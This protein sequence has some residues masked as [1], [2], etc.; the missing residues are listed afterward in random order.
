MGRVNLFRYTTPINSKCG[1]HFVHRSTRVFY[2]TLGVGV[3]GHH[4]GLI[5]GAGQQEDGL[6]RTR[7]R[8]RYNGQFFTTQR[9]VSVL[10]QFSKEL[11]FGFCLTFRTI[12]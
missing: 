8:Y 1:L 4:L 5:V 2:R 6:R 3:V 7:G 9:G 10:G 11:G 12:T